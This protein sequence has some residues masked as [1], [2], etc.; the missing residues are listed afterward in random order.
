MGRAILKPNSAAYQR[1]WQG[2]AQ[3]HKG[4]FLPWKLGIKSQRAWSF[5]YCEGIYNFQ[6]MT[7]HHVLLLQSSSL[8]GLHDIDW[9]ITGQGWGGHWNQLFHSKCHTPPKHT[10]THINGR[11]WEVEKLREKKM[12]SMAPSVHICSFLLAKAF[13][14]KEEKQGILWATQERLSPFW[15][16]FLLSPQ[17]TVEESAIHF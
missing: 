5:P 15:A 3:F 7:S 4:Q 6:G 12:E 11:S 1:G 13:K 14:G 17:S 10:H 8:L 16:I 9:L 2:G